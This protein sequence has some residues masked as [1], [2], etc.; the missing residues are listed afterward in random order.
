MIEADDAVPGEMPRPSVG[1]PRQETG[2]SPN[3]LRLPGLC[4][5]TNF[6]LEALQL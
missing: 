1:V 6:L 3:C 2:A 5:R 4:H